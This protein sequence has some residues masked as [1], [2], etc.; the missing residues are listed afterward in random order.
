MS[1]RH[2]LFLALVAV[3][4]NA[5]AISSGAVD[6]FQ[7]DR[8]GLKLEISAPRD[9][10]IRVRAGMRAL[11][12]DASWAVSAERAPA[13]ATDVGIGLGFQ[14]GASHP[15]VGGQAGSGHAAPQD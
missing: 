3:G 2:F 15:V 6:H 14:R 9:D 11:P 4:L 7:V 12:E 1:L 8:D 13:P 10:I 5:P